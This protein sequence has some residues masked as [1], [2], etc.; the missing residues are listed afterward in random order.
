MAVPGL[1]PGS[2]SYKEAA[3]TLEL[4]RDEAAERDSNPRPK[5]LPTELPATP[6]RCSPQAEGH[7]FSGDGIRG[8]R[9]DRLLGDF[10]TS[11]GYWPAIYSRTPT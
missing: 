11:G 1:A 9:E 6:V 2:T 4:H 7:R 5:A 8:A 10:H 3:L